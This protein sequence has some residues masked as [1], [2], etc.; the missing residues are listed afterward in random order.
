M[1]TKFLSST[2]FIVLFFIN[3]Q[4]KADIGEWKSFAPFYGTEVLCMAKHPN[5]EIF[6]GTQYDGLYMSNDHGNS[7]KLCVPSCTVSAIAIDSTGNI[8]IIIT[9][10]GVQ[11][12]TDGGNNWVDC[13]FP[14]FNDESDFSLAS[15]KD[16]KIYIGTRKGLYLSKDQGTTGLK[17]LIHLFIILLEEFA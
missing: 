15:D 13:N 8:Y 14:S 6:A 11:K 9:L 3:N 4:I 1:K 7:W 17:F 16:G 12:S 2:L 5:G 10:Y